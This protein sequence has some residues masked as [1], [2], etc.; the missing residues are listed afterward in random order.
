MTSCNEFI[1]DK[2]TIHKDNFKTINGILETIISEYTF[3]ALYAIK[4]DI[5]DIIHD[6]NIGYYDNVK[7]IVGLLKEIVDDIGV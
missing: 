1:E 5:E 3:D 6:I 2:N 4:E 7:D